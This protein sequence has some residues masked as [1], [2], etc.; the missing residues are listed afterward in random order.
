M[1][2]AQ[3]ALFCVLGLALA[4]SPA[5]VTF[6]ASVTTGPGLKICV[7][8]DFWPNIKCDYGAYSSI[9]QRFTL[10]YRQTIAIFVCFADDR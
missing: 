1:T 5:M 8:L 9:T 6:D 3:L 4:A 2:F 7:T 10:L